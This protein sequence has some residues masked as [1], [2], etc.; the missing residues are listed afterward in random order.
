VSEPEPLV[1]IVEHT[2][3]I[4]LRIRAATLPALFVAAARGLMSLITDPASV[5]AT[6]VREVR[7]EAPEA[8]DLLRAWLGEINVLH[9]V[10][11]EVYGEFEVTTD[12]R[13]LV[14]RLSGEPFDSARHERRAEVKAVTWHNLTL[15]PTRD[16]FQAEV[17]LDI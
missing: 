6:C 13:T 2:A 12:G 8:A 17:L 5:R 4:G 1:E 9:E 14:G 11:G 16:G 15:E 3:D 7:L 10:H